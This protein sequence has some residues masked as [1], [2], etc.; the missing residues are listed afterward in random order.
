MFFFFFFFS[1]FRLLRFPQNWL[2]N[3]QSTMATDDEKVPEHASQPCTSQDSSEESV[4]LLSKE[5]PGVKRIEIISSHIHLTD[6]IFLFS[7]IFLIAY[8]YGLDNQARQTYQVPSC[9]FSCAIRPRIERI[10]DSCVN[11]TASGHSRIPT[12]Q[13][14]LDNQRLTRCDCSSS[15]A[16]SCKNCRCFWQSRSDHPLDRVLYS[17]YEL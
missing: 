8:V 11:M 12:T 3:G 2:E 13:S 14:D 4:Y 16:Y 5:S 9:N 15:T 7:S 17:W 10:S 6:R 1:H